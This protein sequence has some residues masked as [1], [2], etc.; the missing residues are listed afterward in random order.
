LI[1]VSTEY[2]GEEEE[3]EEEEEETWLCFCVIVFCIGPNGN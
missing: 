2:C 3:E 1:V